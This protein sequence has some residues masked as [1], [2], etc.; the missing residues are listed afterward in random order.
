MWIWVREMNTIPS[1]HI[2]IHITSCEWACNQ[3]LVL[4][5]FGIGL[6]SVETL[7]I[8]TIIKFY[9]VHYGVDGWVGAGAIL[10][11]FNLIVCNKRVLRS[12]AAVYCESF[13]FSSFSL[14]CWRQST[15][16]LID[17]LASNRSLYQIYLCQ[18]EA[19]DTYRRSPIGE[20]RLIRCAMWMH[21][22]ITM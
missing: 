4:F 13:R 16:K 19:S 5:G 21:L 10:Y 11:A 17:L 7:W 6:R 22:V 15:H 1:L 8:Y 14:S 18:T 20:N 2:I 12:S 3:S 9:R